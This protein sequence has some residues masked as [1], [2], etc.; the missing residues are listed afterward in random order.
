MR[1]NMAEMA[2]EDRM[3]EEITAALE[4]ERLAPVEVQQS[5]EKA[6][7]PVQEEEKEETETERVDAETEKEKLKEEKLNS[8]PDEMAV[9]VQVN[10]NGPKEIW[11]YK[12]VPA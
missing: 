6:A 7:Q 4:S 2:K 1:K 10:Q 11:L 12:R 9:H 5:A 3:R 8:I